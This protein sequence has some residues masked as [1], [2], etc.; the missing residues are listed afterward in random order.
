MVE[1]LEAPTLAGGHNKYLSMVFDPSHKQPITHPGPSIGLSHTKQLANGLTFTVGSEG[2][3]LLLHTPGDPGGIIG[4]LYDY[5][6]V[7]QTYTFRQ[8]LSYAQ[9]LATKYDNGVVIASQLCMKNTT[10]ASAGTYVGTFQGVEVLTQFSETYPWPAPD[11]LSNLTTDVRRKTVAIPGAEGIISQ[12]Y[13]A[14]D[15]RLLRLGD[16]TV[17]LDTSG[18][19]NSATT[20]IT[21]GSDD[22]ILSVNMQSPNASTVNKIVPLGYPSYENWVTTCMVPTTFLGSTPAGDALGT[23]LYS[24]KCDGRQGMTVSVSYTGG[25]GTITEPITYATPTAV[26]VAFYGFGGELIDWQTIASDPNF[27]NESGF[28]GILS[29]NGDFPSQNF[30]PTTNP[31]IFPGF[32]QPVATMAVYIA[33]FA[34]EAGTF[35]WPQTDYNINVRSHNAD[36]YANCVYPTRLL[37]MSG[38]A[39]PGSAIQ[40]Q[41]ACSGATVYALVPNPSNQQ[42][43]DVKAPQNYSEFV[44]YEKLLAQLDNLNVPVICDIPSYTKFLDTV[45]KAICDVQVAIDAPSSTAAAK[46]LSRARS[47]GLGD[48]VGSLFHG[49]RDIPVLGGV[50]NE[51]GHVL[52]GSASSQAKASAS[53]AAS[54]AKA[55]QAAAQAANAAA[56]ARSAASARSASWLVERSNGEF[57]RAPS[58]KAL[59][60]SKDGQLYTFNVDGQDLN[61][62]AG[63][64]RKAKQRQQKAKGGT[65][66]NE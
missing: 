25:N 7:T 48:L 38:F 51:I 44:L 13:P 58:G 17:R 41:I 39:L 14:A 15:P 35:G 27:P 4:Y 23:L 12:W 65:G 16:T 49:L 50:A 62:V 61:V 66:N 56:K 34:S 47:F 3:S 43:I 55:A 20:S 53:A 28:Y 26:Q 31:W 9:S 63:R 57:G 32:D 52:T 21:S 36:K 60:K 54:A 8:A 11:Q 40:A 6:N 24:C 29:G 45:A 64:T 5:D 22:L 33:G 46:A 1:R 10:Q 18:I 30:T 59:K 42:D 37:G 19:V 2:Y